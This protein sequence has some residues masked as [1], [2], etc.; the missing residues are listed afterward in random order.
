MCSCYEHSQRKSLSWVWKSDPNVSD[1]WIWWRNFQPM[2]SLNNIAG[3]F[4]MALYS[5]TFRSGTAFIQRKE[6][7]KCHRYHF[8]SIVV[9]VFLLCLRKY[10]FVH[11][12]RALQHAISW[13]KRV[14][15]SL[16]FRSPICSGG[17]SNWCGL[18][19]AIQLLSQSERAIQ[20]A[21]FWKSF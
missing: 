5:L 13:L 1:W 12:G 17:I 14:M 3:R 2:V 4:W 21:P 19:G 7:S 8:R 6:S 11:H 15:A 20:E 16:N 10:C 9:Y 18:E